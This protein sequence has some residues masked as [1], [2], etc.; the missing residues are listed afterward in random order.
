MMI[1]FGSEQTGNVFCFV[2]D[3]K[4]LKKLQKLFSSHSSSVAIFDLFALRRYKIDSI[5]VYF[6]SCEKALF[7]CKCLNRL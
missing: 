5:A 2:F 3:Q 6:L 1:L 4:H 7:T